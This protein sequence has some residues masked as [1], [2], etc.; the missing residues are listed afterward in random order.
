MLF[1]A[2]ITTQLFSYRYGIGFARCLQT[3][4]EVRF[5]NKGM[6]VLE[7]R[8]ANFLDPRF[9]GVLHLF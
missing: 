4:L 6:D 3:N 7:R 5:P 1:N 8:A 9:K 2:T